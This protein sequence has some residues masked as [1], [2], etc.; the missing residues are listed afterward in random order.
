MDIFINIFLTYEEFKVKVKKN[1]ILYFLITFFIIGLFVLIFGLYLSTRQ[2]GIEINNFKYDSNFLL[3][4]NI[5]EESDAVDLKK[6]NVVDIGGAVNFPGPYQLN[7]GDRLFT[8]IKRAGGFR[9]K[10]DRSF[11]NKSLNLTE[12]LKDGQKIYIPFESERFINTNDPDLNGINSNLV[13]INNASQLELE[14][15]PK[16]GVVTASKI[17][18]ARPFVSINE[19]VEKKIISENVLV[20]IENLITI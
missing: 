5:K 18:E 13:S 2:D 6:I 7:Q 9:E 14:N 1:S 4:K 11:L 19:L 15:L 17:I 10:V 16:I 8:L 20:A 3:D 12:I